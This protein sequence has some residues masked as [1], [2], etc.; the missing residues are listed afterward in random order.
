[1]DVLAN[2]AVLLSNY[3]TELAESFID[4]KEVIMYNS[5][6][7][8]VSKSDYYLAHSDLLPSIGIAGYQKAVSLF[9]YEKQVERLLSIDL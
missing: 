9:S 6:E 1:M 7:D 4:G 5:L 8:A 3:Q 2:K